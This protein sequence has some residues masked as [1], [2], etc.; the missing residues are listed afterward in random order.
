MRMPAARTLIGLLAAALLL[1]GCTTPVESDDMDDDRD[2][3][4]GTDDLMLGDPAAVVED[5]D[6]L[7]AGGFPVGWQPRGDEAE[8]GAQ[9]GA[10]HGVGDAALHTLLVA[11]AGSL[12]DL[13]ANVSFVLE[14]GEHPN[15]AGLAIHYA[16]DHNY[17]IIRY[18]TSENGW[19]IF[20]MRDGNRDKQSDATVEGAPTHAF[21]DEVH[22]R[23]HSE[24][25]RVTVYDEDVLAVDYVLPA[26]MSHEGGVGLFIRGQ[27][28][29]AFDDFAVTP[30]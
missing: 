13:D 5:F 3:M 4:D 10:M 22:L 19:H 17:Q 11:P 21:G 29:V 8:W 1:S 26:E 6:G 15:G 9:D 24:D 12:T 23:V 25:G 18:S 30:L 14:A 27:S 7:A 2:G 20:T 28:T 16:D